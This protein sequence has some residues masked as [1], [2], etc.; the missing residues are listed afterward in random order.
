MLGIIILKNI[1]M[2]YEYK[3]Y[4]Y[5]LFISSV[6]DLFNIREYLHSVYSQIILLIILASFAICFFNNLMNR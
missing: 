5:S 2:I 1:R 3:I 4:S 6:I